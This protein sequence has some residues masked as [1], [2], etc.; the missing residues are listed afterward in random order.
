MFLRCAELM[1]SLIPYQK[2][3]S[4][5]ISFTLVFILSAIMCCWR[6]SRNISGS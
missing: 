2:Y 3:A 5:Y 4:V 6:V 1:L